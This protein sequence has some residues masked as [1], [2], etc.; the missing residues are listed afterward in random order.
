MPNNITYRIKEI[1]ESVHIKD[2][3][4]NEYRVNDIV[5]M[6]KFFISYEETDNPYKDYF[7]IYVPEGQGNRIIYFEAGP[8][9][10][11]KCSSE[12][13]R[14]GGWSGLTYSN[15]RYE[16]IINWQGTT[17]Y[18]KGNSVN[19]SSS[20]FINVVDESDNNIKFNVGGCINSLVYGDNFERKTTMPDKK[21]MGTF[22]ETSVVVANELKFPDI[23]SPGGC[24]EMFAGCEHLTNAPDITSSVIEEEGCMYMFF[25]CASL[26]LLPKI[27]ARNIGASGCL[28]MFHGCAAL[29]VPEDYI[30][31]ASTLGESCYYTMFGECKK[32]DR[33]PILPATTL[34]EGCYYGMFSDCSSGLT[35]A[36]IILPATNIPREAYESMFSGCTNLRIIPTI[37]G[38]TLS[39]RCYYGMFQNCTSLTSVNGLNLHSEIVPASAY[40]YMFYG[41][42]GL[43]NGPDIRSQKYDD[44]AC[45]DMFSDCTL[46]TNV[47]LHLDDD[48]IELGE[49]CFSGMFD[50]CT[51]LYNISSDTDGLEYFKAQTLKKGCYSYMFSFCKR[52]SINL[53]IYAKT[54]APSACEGMFYG[55]GLNTQ[56][57]AGG[58]VGVYVMTENFVEKDMAEYDR[59]YRRYIN[60]C[61]SDMCSGCTHLQHI[62]FL[63]KN[64]V[65]GNDTSDVKD[66]VEDYRWLSDLS[67]K[68]WLLEAFGGIT[69]GVPDV[70]NGTVFGRT[71]EYAFRIKFLLTGNVHDKYKWTCATYYRDEIEN[72]RM[73]VCNGSCGK[74]CTGCCSDEPWDDVT[75]EFGTDHSC[76]HECYHVVS[77]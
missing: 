4:G 2:N 9:A 69:Y 25:N 63:A 71:C 37:C 75:K 56:S 45:Q 52:L 29:K 32:L 10:A 60:G 30:L 53:Y 74:G 36:N 33:V 39:F 58:V 18:F 48:R 19:D 70:R 68:S 1:P 65:T 44:Y 43:K 61:F 28:S 31:S 20:L 67:D 17:R 72:D 27:H 35:N 24:Y 38:E 6:E 49:Y 51:N 59:I 26:G 50:H 46:L 66:L 76:N 11:I 62:G 73:D 55:A 21:F 16:L 64:I 40:S 7:K 13:N 22:S 12:N 15:G 14:D 54:L 8:N 3:I 47:L 57:E 23:I 34:A 42:T 77:N 41:C 5:D